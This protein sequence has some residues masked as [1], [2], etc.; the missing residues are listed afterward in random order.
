MAG[1]KAAGCDILALPMIEIKN[2]TFGFGK[3]P[4]FTNVNASVAAGEL[5]R[6]DG[7]NGAGKS[8]LIGI[9]CGL[10]EGYK[11]EII[12]NGPNDFRRWTSWIAADANGLFPSL[13]AI[14]NLDFWLKLRGRVISPEAIRD[15]LKNWGIHGDWTQSSLPTS[16]F[17]T[18]MKR[19]VALAKL[20]QDGSR[21][22]ILDEPLFGLDQAACSKFKITLENH[23]K[24]GGAA[25][26]VTHDSRLLEGINHKTVFLGEA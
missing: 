2:V 12:F 9:L 1:M 11:G 25:I 24:S 6:I 20:E 26:V 22:W 18:G 14:S 10:I 23:L 13:S 21:L 16:K 8:T 4:L 7:A 17:S 19:R 3:K 5:I 15:S